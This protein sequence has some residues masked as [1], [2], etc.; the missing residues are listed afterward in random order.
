MNQPRAVGRRAP[1]AAMPAHV[2]AWVDRTLG[3]P[4]VETADQVG[5]F[6]PGCAT[7]VRC[8]DGTRSS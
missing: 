2:R 1:Y 6:S 8:A 7:R 4:V 3:S 5:G